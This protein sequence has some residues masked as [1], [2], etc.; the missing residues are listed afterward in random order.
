MLKTDIYLVIIK[1]D[2]VKIKSVVYSIVKVIMVINSCI[3]PTYLLIPTVHI[4]NAI[5]ITVLKEQDYLNLV[6]H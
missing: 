1:F 3:A 6:R 4:S 5:Q 2:Q